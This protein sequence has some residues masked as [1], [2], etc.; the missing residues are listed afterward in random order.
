M[1]KGLKRAYKAIEEEEE[2]NLSDVEADYEMQLVAEARAEALSQKTGIV[3][4]A[5][6]C[7]TAGILET[8]EEINQNL[9]WYETLDSSTTPLDLD[10]AHDD[11]KREV[12]FYNNSLAAVR[13]CRAKLDEL[14]EPFRRPVDF[15]CEMVKT[16]RHMSKIKDKLIEEQKKIAAVEQRKKDQAHKKFAK[17]VQASKLK[18]R[19]DA[20]KQTLDAVKKWRKDHESRRG[21]AL[22]DDDGFEAALKAGNAGAVG[23]KKDE[24]AH[25][26]KKRQRADEKWGHG[27][28]KWQKKMNDSKSTNDLSD[29]NPKRGKSL[30]GGGGGRSG[31]NKA[32]SKPNRPGKAN[33]AKA[34]QQKT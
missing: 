24:A 1:P 16:D 15:F 20:K 25:K 13:E 17:E 19:Q 8:L 28:K 4:Q 32:S 26:S 22:A 11:L 9:P 33:R 18:E 21:N 34:R 23:R 27:G 2:E 10:D 12:A 3:K 7:N 6:I 29:F 14:G 30:G 5:F 31:R